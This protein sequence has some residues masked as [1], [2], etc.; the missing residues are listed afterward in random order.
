MHIILKIEAIM[1]HLVARLLNRIHS[2]LSFIVY[3]IV[4]RSMK[5]QYRDWALEIVTASLIRLLR[6]RIIIRIAINGLRFNIRWP[7]IDYNV[8][9]EVYAKKIYMLLKEFEPKPGQIIVD[10]G[11]YIGDYTIF[12]A[13][14][15][16]YVYSIEPCRSNLMLLIQN[17][18]LNDIKR[19]I[20][21]FKVAISD[22]KGYAYFPWKSLDY[23][24]GSYSLT[25]SQDAKMLNIIFEKVPVVTL[26]DLMNKIHIDKIDLIKIDIEGEEDKVLESSV[27]LLK[28][29]KPKIV[30]E[31]HG[32]KKF[33]KIRHLLKN[34]GYIIIP[35]HS[36][37][38]LIV[39]YCIPQVN[40]SEKMVNKL[41]LSDQKQVRFRRN[42]L[43]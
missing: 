30:L 18:L 26:D 3:V 37:K 32:F 15:D 14:Y 42:I 22:H 1:G 29:L 28:R 13:S 36:Y 23:N 6:R 8:L 16:S 2:V 43:P 11:A 4:S 35:K 33:L 7:S 24:P 20:S 39:A 21:I 40:N 10:L 17:I 12:A 27:I 9:S 19:N 31:V 41:S 38:E 25:L 34:M 5:V